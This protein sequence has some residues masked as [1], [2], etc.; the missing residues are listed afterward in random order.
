MRNRRLSAQGVLRSSVRVLAPTCCAGSWSQHAVSTDPAWPLCA[1]SACLVCGMSG[2]AGVVFCCVNPGATVIQGPASSSVPSSRSAQ[3]LSLNTRLPDTRHCPESS[4]APPPSLEQASG[5]GFWTC[6]PDEPSARL[7]DA[8]RLESSPLVDAVL[9]CGSVLPLHLVY[10]LL[11]QERE[12]RVQHRNEHH[13]A[14]PCLETM[15]MGLG[16]R[17]S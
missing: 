9:L 8:G 10:F 1:D 13:G 14:F 4:R 16:D 17:V 6:V 7:P 3:Q 2:V 12:L 11:L 15:S 5:M